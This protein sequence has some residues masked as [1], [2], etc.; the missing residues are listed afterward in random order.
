MELAWMKSHM[1][2]W[3][4]LLGVVLSCALFLTGKLMVE[5][6]RNWAAAFTRHAASSGRLSKIFLVSGK[7]FE[8]VALVGGFVETVAVMVLASG[9]LIDLVTA[10][11]GAE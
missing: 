3:R 7:F 4:H 5:G 1:Q 11:G 9:W 10:A 8:V 2:I 6:C